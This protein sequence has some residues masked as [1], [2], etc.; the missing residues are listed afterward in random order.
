MGAIIGGIARMGLSKAIIVGSV[1]GGIVGLLAH[2][3]YIKKL[4]QICYYKRE[5][6]KKEKEANR[7]EAVYISKKSVF[8]QIIQKYLRN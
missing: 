8:E 1:L 7:W 3:E 2:H 5:A 6:R 4:I